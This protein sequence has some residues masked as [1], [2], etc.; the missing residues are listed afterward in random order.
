MTWHAVLR[1]MR[2]R[3]AIEPLAAGEDSVTTI[4]YASLSAFNAGSATSPGE[5][6]PVPR[7]LQS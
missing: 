5:R 7:V 3:R 2:V 1:R 4:A 6:P